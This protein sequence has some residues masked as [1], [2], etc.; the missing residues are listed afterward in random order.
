MSACSHNRKADEACGEPKELSTDISALC[1]LQDPQE[2]YL[3]PCQ[4]KY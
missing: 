2:T 4:I 1:P 3:H